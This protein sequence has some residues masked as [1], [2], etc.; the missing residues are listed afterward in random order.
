MK[1]RDDQ[2]PRLGDLLAASSA[3]EWK[4]TRD[5]RRPCDVCKHAAALHMLGRGCF[6][7]SCNLYKNADVGRA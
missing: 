5:P 6:G 7:C 1:N 2:Q 4:A 3:S